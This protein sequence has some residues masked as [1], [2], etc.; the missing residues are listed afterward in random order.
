[1]TIF[2]VK[3]WKRKS[4]RKHNR[5]VEKLLEETRRALEIETDPEIRKELYKTLRKYGG[6]LEPEGMMQLGDLGDAEGGIQPKDNDNNY[7]DDS[8]DDKVGDLNREADTNTPQ[9][10]PRIVVDGL[11]NDQR[12]R[13]NSGSSNHKPEVSIDVKD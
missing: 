8:M 12:E 13:M 6:M 5:K 2:F 11:A 3:A 1:M 7:V 9:V 10:G 4:K